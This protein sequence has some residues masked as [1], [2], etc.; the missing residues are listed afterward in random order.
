[1][2]KSVYLPLISFSK[3]QTTYDVY[4]DYDASGQIRVRCAWAAK[5]GLSDYLPI[6]AKLPG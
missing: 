6:V 4:R 1:M 3:C 5:V 2:Y